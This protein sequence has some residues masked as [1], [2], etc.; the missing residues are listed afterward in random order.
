MNIRLSIVLLSLLATIPTAFKAQQYKV[1]ESTYNTTWQQNAFND[2]WYISFGAGAQVIM[3]EDDSKASLGSRVT[4]APSLTIGKYFSP[5]FGLR[6]NFTGG[7]LHGFNDGQDGVYRKWTKNNSSYMG[8]GYNGLAG[9]PKQIGAPFFTV[10]PSW[11]YR[12]WDVNDKMM[13]AENKNGGYQ[14]IPGKN[15]ELYMQHVRY[16]AVNLNAVINF[17]ELFKQYVPDRSFDLSAFGGPT[18]FQVF[19]HMGNRGYAYFGMNLGLN[20]KIRMNDFTD[21]FMEGNFTVYPDDFDGHIGGSG[22]DIVTQL[23]AGVS[24]KIG[25][26]YWERC[27]HAD[28]SLIAR[29]NDE[30]NKLRNKPCCPLIEPVKPLP[31]L[32][33]T[34]IRPEEE[35]V[36]KREISGEAFVIFPV[37]RIEL[38]PSLG[39]NIYELSKITK[40]IDFLNEESDINIDQIYITGY[41]SPEGNEQSNYRLSEGR[42]RSLTEYVRTMYNL[43]PNLFQVRSNGENW[44]GLLEKL[45][46]TSLSEQE[47]MDVKNIITSNYNIVTRKS[48]LQAYQGGRVYRYLLN[49]VYPGLRRTDYKIEFTVPQFT[50]ERGRQLINTKPTMLSQFEIYQIANSYPKGS[51]EFVRAIEI[52]LTIYPNDPISIINAAAVALE[53]DELERAATYLEKVKTDT[54]AL[55]NLGVLYMLQGKTQ[56]AT[57]YFRLAVENGDERAAQNLKEI[58]GISDKMRKYNEDMQKYLEALEKV[59]KDK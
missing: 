18:L 37:G 51:P 6:T 49:D 33:I 44:D 3:A 14:W 34:Y 23:T 15:G 50:V 27:D 19:S 12:G 7:S 42:S 53:R 57:V 35:K 52:G 45:D 17:T 55:N 38:N 26:Q 31:S 2:N 59:N 48:R 13:F 46:N 9:Y 30:I 5:I 11:A 8:N 22:G 21:F 56:D 58:N 40:S 41:A 43:S 29:L 28:Y 24:C 32:S 39:N 10:D 47:K 4:F 16:A 20:A 1:P 25:K 36:K 54:R